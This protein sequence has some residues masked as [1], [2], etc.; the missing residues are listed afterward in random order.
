MIEAVANGEKGGFDIYNT[1]DSRNKLNAS[2][3]ASTIDRNELEMQN[4]DAGGI[5]TDIK[6]YAAAVTAQQTQRSAI[7]TVSKKRKNKIV[8]DFEPRVTNGD[9]LDDNNLLPDINNG[10]TNRNNESIANSMS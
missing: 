2:R 5:W 3:L 8:Q 6:D 10:T 7:S 4:G 1:A 9:L